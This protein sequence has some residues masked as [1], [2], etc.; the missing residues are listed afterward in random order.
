MIHCNSFMFGHQFSLDNRHLP[1]W[2][3]SFSVKTGY[4]QVR[5]Q[6][7]S[8][9]KV[10]GL[11]TAWEDQCGL[12]LSTTGPEGSETHHNII[13]GWAVLCRKCN[14]FLIAHHLQGCYSRI[15]ECYSP[16]VKCGILSQCHTGVWHSLHFWQATS[17]R[18][19][20]YQRPY[21]EPL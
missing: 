10:G 15:W 21:F 17:T 6:S 18:G 20:T 2:V 7:T 14:P 9:V 16:E 19:L 11:S 8:G 1:L 3:L 4:A 12:H 13:L 5:Q